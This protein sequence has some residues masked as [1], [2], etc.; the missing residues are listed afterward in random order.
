MS[1]DGPPRSR[2]RLGRRQRTTGTRGSLRR[3]RDSCSIQRRGHCRE[4]GGGTARWT[5]GPDAGVARPRTGSLVPATVV[6]R[7]RNSGVGC[8]ARGSVW[9]GH[10]R[11]GCGGSGRSG[12]VTVDID[13]W[14]ATG[15]RAAACCP[16]A[17]SAP[18]T[19]RS[20]PIVAGVFQPH[21]REAVG[22]W[23]SGGRPGVQWSAS[24]AR[25]APSRG[26]PAVA[27]RP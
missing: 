24:E 16:P 21:S 9:G 15:G 23:D 25:S 10:S 22:R 12:P 4:S 13:R 26:P 11:V 19:S 6:G 18:A 20:G 1:L 17:S 5:W 2:S 7:A 8:A 3:P 14:I 27:A